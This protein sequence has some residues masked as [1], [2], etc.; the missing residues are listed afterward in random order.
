VV[1]QKI[2]AFA[3]PLLCVILGAMDDMRTRSQRSSSRSIVQ[4]AN[5]CAYKKLTARPPRR[6]LR[7][8]LFV[9]DGRA[10][11]NQLGSPTT[12]AKVPSGTKLTASVAQSILARLNNSI[13]LFDSGG[14]L[15]S[16]VGAFG[17][18]AKTSP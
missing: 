5:S 7:A 12:K 15:D 9:C 4:P 8:G 14:R 10:A 13:N 16:A 6:A 18:K 1:W 17:L 11:L 2:E 3:G